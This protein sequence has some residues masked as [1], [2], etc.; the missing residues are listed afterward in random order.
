MSEIRVATRYAKS[1]IELAEEKGV[2][3]SINNDMLLFTN[4][5]DKAR[6]LKL[7]LRNPIINRDAKLKS[8]NRIFAN[9]FNQITLAFFD[10]L[11]KKHRESILDV[12]A[13][14]FH[15]QYNEKMH[16][17][18]AVITTPFV[19]TDELRNSFMAAVEELS[20]RKVELKEKINPE[21]IGGFVL[22]INDKQIDTSISSRLKELRVKFSENPYIREF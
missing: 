19:L 11:V 21:L 3:E 5:C 4:T 1:L 10:I 12:I 18:N 16:I 22:Q 17:E 13:K 9:H 8:L 2:L 7:M 15:R 6:D 20:G 14:E